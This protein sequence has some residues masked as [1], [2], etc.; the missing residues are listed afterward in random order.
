MQ[1]EKI[2]KKNMFL[3]KKIKKNKKLIFFNLSYLIDPSFFWGLTSFS[4]FIITTIS[5][6][7]NYFFVELTN[8]F[9]LIDFETLQNNLLNNCFIKISLCET[10]DPEWVKSFMYNNKTLTDQSSVNT[11]NKN[12]NDEIITISLL[13]LVITVA[14]ILLENHKIPNSSLD[15]FTLLGETGLVTTIFYTS[16]KLLIKNLR[17][18]NQLPEKKLELNGI[19]EEEGGYYGL[20]KIPSMEEQIQKKILVIGT[21]VFSLNDENSNDDENSSA[22]E[23]KDDVNIITPNDATSSFLNRF[24]TKKNVFYLV[25]KMFQNNE[26]FLNLLNIINQYLNMFFSSNAIDI[27]IYNLPCFAPLLFYCSGSLIDFLK[28]YSFKLF[29]VYISIYVNKTYY[30]LKIILDKYTIP[31]LSEEEA[32]SSGDIYTSYRSFVK[33]K[34]DGLLIADIFAQEVAQDS[35]KNFQ[36]N[37]EIHPKLRSFVNNSILENNILNRYSKWSFEYFKCKLKFAFEFI[38]IYSKRPFLYCKKE[39]DKYLFLEAREKYTNFSDAESIF[40]VDLDKKK[41]ESYKKYIKHMTRQHTTTYLTQTL[42]KNYKTM[43]QLKI[44]EHN[45][46]YKQKIYPFYISFQDKNFNPIIHNTLYNEFKKNMQ[47]FKKIEQEIT[48]LNKTISFVI[49]NDPVNSYRNI[50]KNKTTLFKFLNN[51]LDSILV[52]SGITIIT[53]GIF[54]MDPT[55]AISTSSQFINVY[56]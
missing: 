30:F 26:T 43:L 2:D 54:I 47:D 56:K 12:V 41:T 37:T 34:T 25:V 42:K 20:N 29:Y 53:I 51:N 46:F 3:K 11:F 15:F 10:T 6:N 22:P 48:D 17:K 1:L 52:I 19:D 24:K 45:K 21:L 31:L 4:L 7:I 39:L 23:K 8:N 13:T 18:Q 33:T 44:T 5:I 50:I 14:V 32:Q 40:R 38:P 35:E 55:T 28:E 36:L 9:N 27:F 16:F 49:E